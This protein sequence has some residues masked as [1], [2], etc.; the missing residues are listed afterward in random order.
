[1]RLLT[2]DRWFS[3][4]SHGKYLLLPGLVFVLHLAGFMLMDR[5]EAMFYLEKVLPGQIPGHGMTGYMSFVYLLFRL[6]FIAQALFYLIIN[7]KLIFAH[8]QR[9]EDFYS[10]VENRKLNWV[11]F[12]NITLGFTSLASIT[13]AITGRDAFA[14]DDIYLAIPSLIFSI[15]LFII[16]FLGNIQGEVNPEADEKETG[17]NEFDGSRSSGNIKNA[18]GQHIKQTDNIPSGDKTTAA[19]E[20]SNIAADRQTGVKQDELPDNTSTNPGKLKKRMESLFENDMI[21]RNPDLKIWDVSSLLGTNRT[22][23][24]KIINTE[25]GRNF[26]N[27]VNYYRIQYAK[28]IIS[29]NSQ[30]TNEEVAELSGFGSVNSLYRAFRLVENK[31]IGDFR[32]SLT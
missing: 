4:R 5:S 31:T 8:N 14:E 25:Y 3:V 13:V 9:I 27:H 29:T 11:Q 26:C 12:F 16:G 10:N 28:K 23:I 22:Y 1:M 7:F 19:I 30:L 24:S 20:R 32:N 17:M 18:P 2:V 15:M 21:F 6:V